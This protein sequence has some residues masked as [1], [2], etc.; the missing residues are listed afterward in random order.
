[1]VRR[2]MTTSGRPDKS[3]TLLLCYA[4]GCVA[5]APRRSPRRAPKPRR[6][7]VRRSV[8]TNGRPVKSA[9]CY[10]PRMLRG[11]LRN[12]AAKMRGGP[13]QG[14]LCRR[15]PAPCCAPSSAGK[16]VIEGAFWTGTARLA[17]RRAAARAAPCLSSSP[18]PHSR[19]LPHRPPMPGPR[20]GYCRFHSFLE[21]FIEGS[22][23]FSAF[24]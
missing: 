22:I 21:C 20:H 15:G 3:A 1:M 13:C 4:G 5:A 19:S 23:A 12:G 6:E 7:D 16:R 17:R 14:P 2:G 10:A 11:A 9:L 8:S 24:P 18:S